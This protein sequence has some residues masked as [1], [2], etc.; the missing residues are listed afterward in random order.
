[1]IDF[2]LCPNDV[3]LTSFLIKRIVGLETLKGELWNYLAYVKCRTPRKGGFWAGEAPLQ[4][5]TAVLSLPCSPGLS[6]R[7]QHEV[8]QLNSLP[9][10]LE[11]QTVSQVFLSALWVEQGWVL[12]LRGLTKLGTGG[13]W[14]WWAQGTGRWGCFVWRIVVCCWWSV[15]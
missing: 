4:S 8:L 1:M 2:L 12:A 13:T 14:S 5:I 9:V 6:L 11:A 15:R 3:L 7:V 10:Q